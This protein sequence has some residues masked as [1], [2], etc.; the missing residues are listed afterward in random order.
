MLQIMWPGLRCVAELI[1]APL[2][3]SESSQDTC[4][5]NMEPICDKTIN[6]K[7]STLM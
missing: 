4:T 1:S 3:Q 2:L 7:C 6:Q 5:V